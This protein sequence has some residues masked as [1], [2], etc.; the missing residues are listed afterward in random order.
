MG[1]SAQ[2]GL[3][4]FKP[5]ML[6]EGVI[7]HR[8]TVRLPSIDAGRPVAAV[9]RRAT[10]ARSRFQSKRAADSRTVATSPPQMMAVHLAAERVR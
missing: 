2:P 8:C 3:P 6:N 5:S 7:D 4:I 10:G 1:L 9:M